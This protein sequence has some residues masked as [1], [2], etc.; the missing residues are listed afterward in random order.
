VLAHLH[1]KLVVA[2]QILNTL[3]GAR[4]LSKF[5]VQ[6]GFAREQFSARISAAKLHC[7]TEGN[8]QIRQN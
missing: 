5:H 2:S 1:Q 6:S 4:C 3:T 8:P 7:I